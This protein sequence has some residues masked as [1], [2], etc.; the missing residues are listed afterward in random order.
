MVHDGTN[1]GGDRLGV[2]RQWRQW[3]RIENQL[4]QQPDIEVI[5]HVWSTAALDYATLLKLQGSS[6]LLY[7]PD[8]R[9]LLTVCCTPADTATMD[10]ITLLQRQGLNIRPL[11]MAQEMLFR[12]AIGRNLAGKAS[13]ARVVWYTDCDYCFG[14]GALDELARQAD[15]LLECPLA[16]PAQVYISTSHADGDMLTRQAENQALPDFAEGTFSPRRQRIAIGG[17]QIAGGDYARAHGYLD[18]TDWQLPADPRRGFLSCRCDRAYRRQA[19]APARTLDLPNIY[20]VRHSENGR[21]YDGDGTKQGR[22][23]WR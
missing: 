21:D 2:A 10:T 11:T 15:S 13:R 3:R 20:R 8:C 18:G 23:V 5:T 22:R 17:V 1:H 19:A 9:V 12:R 6:L 7:Q 16:K 4:Q 14:D